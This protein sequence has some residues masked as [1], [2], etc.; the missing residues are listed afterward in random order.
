MKVKTHKKYY[1]SYSDGYEN[2]NIATRS[3]TS[4]VIITETNEPNCT[5]VAHNMQ[6]EYT[7]KSIKYTIPEN[8]HPINK[9]GNCFFNCL[10]YI[11]F[12]NKN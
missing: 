7:K 2:Q 9:D 3:L 8:I 11:F 5:Q 6:I 1:D 10:S 4:P 12:G